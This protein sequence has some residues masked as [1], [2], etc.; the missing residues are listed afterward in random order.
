[1]VKPIHTS[2]EEVATI[3]RPAIH[4]LSRQATL[5]LPS[6]LRRNKPMEG[7]SNREATRVDT[8]RLRQRVA[9]APLIQPVQVRPVAA[10]VTSTLRLSRGED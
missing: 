5:T 8:V 7:D 9:A 6:L 10:M 3:K 4:T 2:S 1:M